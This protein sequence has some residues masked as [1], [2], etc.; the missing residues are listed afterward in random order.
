MKLVVSL[1]MLSVGAMMALAGCGSAQVE[2]K[3]QQTI[4][5]DAAPVVHVDNS[6]GDIRISGRARA[7]VDIEAT[8][9]ARNSDD[10]RNISVEVRRAGADLFVATKYGNGRHSGGVTYTISVPTDASVDVRNG[11]GTV[12]V[13]RVNGNVAVVNQ[14]GRITVKLG[15]VAAR[16]AV[17]LSSA[18]GEVNLSI[19]RDSSAAVEANTNVGAINSDFPSVSEIRE[20][21][22]GAHANGKVGSGSARVRLTV[23]TGAINLKSS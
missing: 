3:L 2:Q 17:D 6:A 22:V 14:A 9:E 11:A 19:A 15:R 20:N 12:D 7:A 13:A 21:V 10:L 1:G 23:G 18:V 16:R 5:T 4:A 8:K